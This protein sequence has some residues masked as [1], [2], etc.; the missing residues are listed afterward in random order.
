MDIGPMTLKGYMEAAPLAKKIVYL[1]ELKTDNF[2]PFFSLNLNSPK[3]YEDNL[4]RPYIFEGENDTPAPP[5]THT[6]LIVGEY[7]CVSDVR[8]ACRPMAE[9]SKSI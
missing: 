9:Y 2:R 5:H 4:G 1:G 8:Y 6:H 7:L 3:N